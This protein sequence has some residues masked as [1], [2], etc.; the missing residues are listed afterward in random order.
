MRRFGTFAVI[1]WSGEAVARPKGLAL[2]VASAGDEAPALVAHPERRWSRQALL[3]WLRA[4]SNDDLLIGLDLSPGLPF[5]DFGSFFPGWHGSPCTAKELWE[6][7]DTLSTDTRHLGANGF[8][9]YQPAREH[10][11]HQTY[12]GANYTPDNG[13][14]RR[15]EKRQTGSPSS[16]F[17]LIGAKQVGKSSLTGMRVLHRLNGSI[18]VWPFDDVPQSGAMIL[19]IYPSIAACAAGRTAG[20][21]KMRSYA[22]L[23]AALTNPAIGSR[24]TGLVGPATDHATDALL[25]VAWLR[26]NAT[27]PALWSPAGLEEVRHTE[28]WTFGVP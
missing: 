4:H 17:K 14:L 22:D 16:C 13:R 11:L 9:A 1:D 19:E 18:P 21:S 24:P 6:R 15:C 8:L 3:D 28:G 2:A 10:F 5:A 12:R 23:D 26:A 27:A 25:T 20:T 7:V